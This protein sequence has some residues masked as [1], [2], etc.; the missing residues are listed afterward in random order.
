MPV[1]LLEGAGPMLAK[2]PG[3]G[4]AMIVGGTGSPLGGCNVAPK[5]ISNPTVG[6]GT[7]L[8][9]D[10]GK[11]IMLITR[12]APLGGELPPPDE[13]NLSLVR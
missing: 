10:C 6:V 2:T 4:K 1:W 9:N 8:S 3:V 13:R 12:S 11:G 5:P 7:P